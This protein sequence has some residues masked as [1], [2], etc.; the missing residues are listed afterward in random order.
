MNATDP[1]AGWRAFNRLSA[2][3]SRHL[4]RS[5]PDHPAYRFPDDVDDDLHG[6]YVRILRD[7]GPM[8]NVKRVTHHGEPPSGVAVEPGLSRC[9]GCGEPFLREEKIWITPDGR[10]RH[11]HCPP[12]DD[13]PPFDEPELD[14]TLR[15]G[16]P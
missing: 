8:Q 12:D 1:M 10:F 5:Q 13:E 11:I 2:A 14:L 7:V 15:G 9:P 3:V 4:A 16:C 6:A